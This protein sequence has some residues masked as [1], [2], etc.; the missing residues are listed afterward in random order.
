[1]DSRGQVMQASGITFALLDQLKL[2]LNFTYEV[3]IPSQKDY[4]GIVDMVA[5]GEAQM[6]GGIVLITEQRSKAVNFSYPVSWEPY[7]LLYQK[8]QRK[9]RLTLFLD[10]F[11][12]DVW[13]Y[14]FLTFLA[15][16]PVFWIIH[17]GSYYYKVNETGY[18][19]LGK[20][21]H[22]IWYTYGSI[23]GQGGKIWHFGMAFN[24]IMILHLCTFLRYY[25]SRS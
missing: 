19:G 4:D 11:T 23:L 6:S 24:N 25:G 18:G 12:Y 15:I 20:L 10:P 2:H 3:V 7:S 14:I 1:M 16:G 9:S 17:R 13:L 8:P 5:S 21:Q 22:C